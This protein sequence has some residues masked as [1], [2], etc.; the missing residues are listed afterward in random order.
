[1]DKYLCLEPIAMATYFDAFKG[2][3][4]SSE[5]ISEQYESGMVGT[6][7]GFEWYQDQNVAVHTVGPLGGTPVV[8]GASQGVLT[9]VPLYTDLITDGWTAAAAA[10][11]NVGDVVTVAGV[12]AVNPVNRQ[13]LNRLRQFAVASTTEGV[14][15]SDASGNAT[16]RLRP[17][18]IAGG[19]F[20]NVTA[21]P[22]DGAAITVLGAASTITP[23]NM[24]FHKE[25]F[26]YAMFPLVRPDGVD[27]SAVLVDPVTGISIR[28]VR[29]YQIGT[30]TFPARFDIAYALGPYNPEWSCRI[31]G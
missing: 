17:A 27:D 26:A 29:Q 18:I 9:G 28:Y 16:I 7:A 1:M 4:Q 11:L 8:N 22:A 10:R 20:Q 23:Q 5:R 13:T 14:V 6:A 25:A 12:N 30:D 2:L 3:F 31:A 21:R 19:Q 24:A 15:S